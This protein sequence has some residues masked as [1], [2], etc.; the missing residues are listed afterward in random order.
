M[1]PTAPSLPARQ[2]P[3]PP[4]IS[5]NDAG[6][7]SAVIF[8]LHWPTFNFRKI[9]VSRQEDTCFPTISFIELV[10]ITPDNLIAFPQSVLMAIL[11]P[12]LLH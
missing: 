12:V 9:H 3:L 1:N 8:K 10:Q 6:P 11:C 2:H 4:E 5:W 7:P